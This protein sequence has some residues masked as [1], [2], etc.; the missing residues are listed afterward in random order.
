MEGPAPEVALPAV[1]QRTAVKRGA[2]ID[3]FMFGKDRLRRQ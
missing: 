3:F 1:S 2:P